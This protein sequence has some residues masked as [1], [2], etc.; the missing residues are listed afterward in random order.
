MSSDDDHIRPTRNFE[1][2][3]AFASTLVNDVE[4]AGPSKISAVP[5]KQHKTLFGLAIETPNIHPGSDAVFAAKAQL[6]NQALLDMGMGL[7]QW[8]LFLMTGVGWF[9]DSVSSHAFDRKPHFTTDQVRPII[10]L[11]NVFPSHCPISWK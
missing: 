4:K 7:Y 10:V 8:M 6:L 9:L 5:D 3:S 11:D 1:A 2:Q